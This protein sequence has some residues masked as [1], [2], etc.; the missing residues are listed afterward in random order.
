MVCVCVCVC[1]SE[2]ER[3]RES[4]GSPFYQHDLVIMMTLLERRMKDDL[5]KTFKIIG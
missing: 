1:V 3:K 5:I 2:R 4:R